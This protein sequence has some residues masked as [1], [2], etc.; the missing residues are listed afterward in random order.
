MKVYLVGPISGCTY[1]EA[2]GWRKMVTERIKS[3]G[4][5]IFDPMKG[6]DHLKNKSKIMGSYEN[7]LIAKDDHI[8]QADLYRIRQADIL[9]CN[10]SNLKRYS[11]GSFFEVGYGHALNKSIIIVA[12][13][14]MIVEHPFIK[15]SALVAPSIDKGI[16]ILESL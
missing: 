13:N 12:T 3:L 5:T 7:D 4:Y 9:F 16:Q 1:E 6:M 10:F 8:F 15:N 11:V 14:K 2:T